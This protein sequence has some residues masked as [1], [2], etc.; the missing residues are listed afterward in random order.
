[1]I[2]QALQGYSATIFAFGQTGSGKTFTITG[3]TERGQLPNKGIIPRAIS[4]LYETVKELKASGKASAIRVQASYLEIYNENVYDLL[5]NNSA[6]LAVRWTQDRGFFVENLLIVDCVVEDDALAVLAEGIRNR[7]TASHALNMHSSR[8]HSL[9]T[10]YLEIKDFKGPDGTTQNRYGKICFVDLAGSER[11]NVVKA[12]METF[13][14]SLSINTALLALGLCISALSDPKRRGHIPFRDSKLTKL[15][16]DSLSGKGSTMMVACVSPS[17]ENVNETLKTLRYATQA[18]KIQS[19]PVIQLD[20]IEEKLLNLKSEITILKKENIMLREILIKEGKY[21]NELTEISKTVS[22]V[23]SPASH[24]SLV[25]GTSVRSPSGGGRSN[26]DSSGSPKLNRRSTTTMLRSS[27]TTHLRNSTNTQLRSPEKPSP[28]KRSQSPSHQDELLKSI[29]SPKISPLTIKPKLL[30]K[31]DTRSKSRSPSR[32][33]TINDG[34][35]PEFVISDRIQELKMSSTPA[36]KDEPKLRKSQSFRAGGQISPSTTSASIS[37]R[38]MTAKSIKADPK[39]EQLDVEFRNSATRKKTSS[40]TAASETR[41][42]SAKSDQPIKKPVS[43]KKKP[44][45]KANIW[46]RPPDIQ[47]KQKKGFER[48]PIAPEMQ[49]RTD[50][51]MFPPETED[52]TEV[53]SENEQVEIVNQG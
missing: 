46:S 22:S 10:L 42:A 18:Q 36:G 30:T 49:P 32:N 27:T 38:P 1:M 12:D 43:L 8:S 25:D 50:P 28:T 31:K 14:E 26:Y 53:A 45:T 48:R 16:S 39:D 9:L 34:P 7:T 33:P 6:T 11:A 29:V 37:G 15:L 13:K 17:Q 4:H 20:P 40:V 3:P 5:N 35:P 19:K 51:E 23:K 52:P 47:V 41:P 2:S 44:T 21:D 24:Q